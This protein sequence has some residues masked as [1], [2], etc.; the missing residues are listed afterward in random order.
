MAI[1]YVVKLFCHWL[2]NWLSKGF[3][4]PKLVLCIWN[5]LADMN[6][7]WLAKMYYIQPLKVDLKDWC[8]QLIKPFASLLAPI[9]QIILLHSC[10]AVFFN[11]WSSLKFSFNLTFFIRTSKILLSL[12]V[13]ISFSLL[14]SSYFSKLPSS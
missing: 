4:Q 9:S 3:N 14:Y 1:N 5:W 13:L 12:N 11:Q 7:H 10:Q 8:L 6:Q 2:P